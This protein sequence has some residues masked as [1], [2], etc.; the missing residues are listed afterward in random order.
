MYYEVFSEE[1]VK[2]YMFLQENKELIL[3]MCIRRINI[4]DELKADIKSYEGYK[5]RLKISDKEVFDAVIKSLK[6]QLGK[7]KYYLCSKVSK[8]IVDAFEEVLFTDGNL[9]E[10]QL[11]KYVTALK[12]DQL[13]YESVMDMIDDLEER[14]KCNQHLSRIPTFTVWKILNY[15]RRKYKDNAVAL[16]ALDKYYNI[17]RTM[18]TGMDSECG[19]FLKGEECEDDE[20]LS[21]YYSSTI[22]GGVPGSY[23]IC[24]YKGNKYETEDDYFVFERELDDEVISGE[25]TTVFMEALSKM[26]MLNYDTKMNIRNTLYGDVKRTLE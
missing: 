7:D 5:K 26:P 10:T 4:D 14:R 8:K 1:L 21:K 17:E 6:E 13:M 12:N 25:A 11:Y 2:R 20:K 15:V 16:E 23:I 24:D 18:F 22:I 19:Y 3:A 9:E